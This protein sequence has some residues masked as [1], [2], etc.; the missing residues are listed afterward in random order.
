MSPRWLYW[1]AAA[2]GGIGGAELWSVTGP[3][4][5]TNFSG[6]DPSDTNCGFTFSA[7]PDGVIGF[8]MDEDD[9]LLIQFN[10]S[11][12]RTAFVATYPP[13]TG[14]AIVSTG[15]FS[16]QVVTWTSSTN[17][18]N[19]CVRYNNP[20]SVSLADLRVDLASGSAFTI[21]FRTPS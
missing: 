3:G 11:G 9:R 20:T 1:P 15:A 10:S 16:D 13:T 18:N 12:A 5:T 21:T 14:L 19:T 7:T 4:S 17:R 6:N 8:Q 2:A